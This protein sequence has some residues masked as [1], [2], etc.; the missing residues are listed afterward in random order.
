[1][2]DLTGSRHYVSGLYTPGTVMLQPAG[3]I[4]GFGDG[5]RRDGVSVSREQPRSPASRARAAAGP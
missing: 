1:M 3:Y 4:R 5:L 2:H